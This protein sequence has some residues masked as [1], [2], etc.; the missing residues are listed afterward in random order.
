MLVIA[1]S[2]D[3]RVLHTTLTKEGYIDALGLW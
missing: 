2:I 3:E 1:N